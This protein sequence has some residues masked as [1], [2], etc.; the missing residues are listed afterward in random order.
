MR[1]RRRRSISRDW[2]WTEC[3]IKQIV[4]LLAHQEGHSSH[5]LTY[6]CP[7]SS[8]ISHFRSAPFPG[9]LLTCHYLSRTKLHKS[10]P[11]IS[12]YTSPYI[13]T[14]LDLSR[15]FIIISLYS[16]IH[17]V[18]TSG[19]TQASYRGCQVSCGSC[20]GAAQEGKAASAARHRPSRPQADASRRRTILQE[21]LM[22]RRARKALPPAHQSKLMTTTT[23][24]HHAAYPHLVLP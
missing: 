4:G 19:T 10:Q 11:Q 14:I 2:A 13:S 6:K 17:C 16:S 21:L 3:F 5:P 7:L 20:Y 12:P 15:M 23:P 18:Y 8:Q 24:I 9:T 22:A 1:S